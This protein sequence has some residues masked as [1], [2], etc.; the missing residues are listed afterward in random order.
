MKAINESR[1][2]LFAFAYPTAQRQSFDSYQ[3]LYCV[4]Y[5]K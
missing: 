2:K 4:L 3:Q 1:L 5:H